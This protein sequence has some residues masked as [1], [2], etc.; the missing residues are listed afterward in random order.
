VPSDPGSTSAWAAGSNGQIVAVLH[1]PRGKSKADGL[2]RF[3][4]IFAVPPG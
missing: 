3:R 1:L 4:A 2:A